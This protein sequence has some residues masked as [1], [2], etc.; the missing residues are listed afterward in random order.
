MEWQ[1]NAIKYHYTPNIWPKSQTL[2]TPNSGENVEPPERF[3]NAGENAKWFG[4]FGRQFG[5]F[6]QK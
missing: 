4:H 5:I 1:I 3:F 2:T 6:L